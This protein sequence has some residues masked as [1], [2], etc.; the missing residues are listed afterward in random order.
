MV[1]GAFD[2]LHP[3]RIGDAEP[4]RERVQACDGSDG[5]GRQ[6]RD[7]WFGS[8]C[9]QPFY[10]DLDSGADQ[11]VFGKN[12]AQRVDLARVAA[13]KWGQGGQGVSH[14]QGKRGREHQF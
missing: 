13:I 2:L 12:R 7:T 9:Q 14:G 11:A 4:I 10:F 8:Q 5:K 1:G 3:R 6:F